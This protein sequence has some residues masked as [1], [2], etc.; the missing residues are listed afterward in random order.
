[1]VSVR[2]TLELMHLFYLYSNFQQMK[3][4]KKDICGDIGC[5]YLAIDLS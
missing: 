4:R 5:I 3:I 2:L 1:M